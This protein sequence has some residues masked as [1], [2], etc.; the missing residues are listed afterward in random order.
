LRF[1]YRSQMSQLTMTHP[2]KP[3]LVPVHKRQDVEYIE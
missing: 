2:I 1:N 3:K